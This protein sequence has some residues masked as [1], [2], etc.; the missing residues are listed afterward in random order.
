MPEK[1][2]PYITLKKVACEAT[3]IGLVAVATYLVDAGFE[4]LVL[5]CPEYATIIL[6]VSAIVRGLLNWYKH[7]NK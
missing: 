2:D 4:E 6:V 3:T 1:Y 5:G 7:K